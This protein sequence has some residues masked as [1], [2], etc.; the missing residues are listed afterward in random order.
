MKKLVL[1]CILLS[2]AAVAQ[3]STNLDSTAT[4]WTTCIHPNCDPGGTGVP[5]ATLIQ[6]T[7]KT[8][9]I[10]S[11]EIQLTGPDSTNALWYH[12]NGAST[13]TYFE[14]DLTVYVTSLTSQ[15]LEYDIFEY[16]SP[17][18][19]MWGSECVMGGVW[20]IWDGLDHAWVHTTIPCKL[21]IGWH[22]IQFWVHRVNGD[23][24]C[25]GFPCLRYDTL[26][27]D[28]VYYSLNTTQPSEYLHAGWSNQSGLNVQIDL[29]KAGTVTEYLRKVNLIGLN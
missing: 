4:G 1:I 27:V 12:L 20:D 15:A 23:F 11:L 7:G 22:H 6:P 14:A 10:N 21:G 19:Y 17:Y 24:S 13:S 8:W 18:R 26:G 16:L 3:F 5:T 2:S 25:Q 29:N 28:N 9:P